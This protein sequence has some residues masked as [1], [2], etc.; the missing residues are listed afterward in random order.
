MYFIVKSAVYDHGVMWIGED[1]QEGKD[2]ADFFASNFDDGF[3]NYDLMEFKEPTSDI[4]KYWPDGRD[5]KEKSD[6]IYIGL[7]LANRKELT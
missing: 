7:K 3:H 1:L 5:W 6:H 2:K 4:S